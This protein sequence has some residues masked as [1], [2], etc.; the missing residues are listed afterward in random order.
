MFIFPVATL[1]TGFILYFLCSLFSSRQIFKNLSGLLII[2]PYGI[3][4]Y[5]QTS[6]SPTIQ[7]RPSYELKGSKDTIFSI[8]PRN[9]PLTNTKSYHATEIDTVVA[10]TWGTTCSGVTKLMLWH[11]VSFCS[12]SIRSAISSACQEVK[13]RDYR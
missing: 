10:L 6:Y 7:R 4:Q 9:R 5:E 3:P 2:L 12:F 1:L 11:L 8:L 13:E